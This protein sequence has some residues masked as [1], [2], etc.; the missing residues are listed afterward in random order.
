MQVFLQRFIINP[1]VFFPSRLIKALKKNLPPFF[2]L[3]IVLF[4]EE[5]EHSNKTYQTVDFTYKN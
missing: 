2:P 4:K 3:S 1:D 5:G